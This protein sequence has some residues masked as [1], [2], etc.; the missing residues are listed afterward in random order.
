MFAC[1]MEVNIE[2]WTTADKILPRYTAKLSVDKHKQETYHELRIP[3]RDVSACY[4]FTYLRVSI[5]ICWTG[6]DSMDING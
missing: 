1:S 5:D 3:E 6:T 2:T 4:L